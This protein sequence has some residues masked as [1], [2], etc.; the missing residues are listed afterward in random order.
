M[1]N[2]ICADE[3]CIVSW[4]GHRGKAKLDLRGVGLTGP[5]SAYN[6]GNYIWLPTCSRNS[7]CTPTEAN[8]TGSDHNIS[9]DDL[10]K[11]GRENFQTC[12]ARYTGKHGKRVCTHW[13]DFQQ[14]DVKCYVNGTA[15]DHLCAPE[16]DY[17]KE[18]GECSSG[19]MRS[20]TCQVGRIRDQN[21]A[22]K[23]R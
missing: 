16:D 17:G 8:W 14:G 4:Q 5:V 3:S 11:F 13:K 18:P 6:N 7:D 23:N 2:W 9:K 15:H 22:R 10:L 12:S 19:F 20:D 21:N 1:S